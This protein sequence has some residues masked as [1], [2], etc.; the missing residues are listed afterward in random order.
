[1][2]KLDINNDKLTDLPPQD[3]NEEQIKEYVFL[4]RESRIRFPETEDF[5]IKLALEAYIR[6]VDKPRIASKE[7]I[8]ELKRQYLEYKYDEIELAT[9]PFEEV[10]TVEAS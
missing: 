8:A 7:E 1:M 5:I 9:K 2:V 3:F 10:K 6:G 4:L